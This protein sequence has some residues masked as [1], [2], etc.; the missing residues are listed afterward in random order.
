MLRVWSLCGFS[1]LSLHRLVEPRAF[2]ARSCMGSSRSTEEAAGETTM[3]KSFIRRGSRVA[4]TKSFMR[5]GI[6]FGIG[7]VSVGMTSFMTE[8]MM[9]KDPSTGNQLPTTLRVTGDELDLIALGS[10]AVT[11]LKIN[12]YVLGMYVDKSLLKGSTDLAELWKR[13]KG[14]N[15]QICFTVN[16]VRN[17]NAPHLVRGF[18]TA[19]DK[20]KAIGKREDAADFLDDLTSEQVGEMDDAIERFKSAFPQGNLVPG[21]SLQLILDPHAETVEMVMGEQHAMVHSAW[22]AKAIYWSYVNPQQP[23]SPLFQSD[24]VENLNRLN[25]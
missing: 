4:R 9:R 3:F 6:A 19:L 1:W 13:L 2:R 15:A 23:S 24:L 10:K 22:L 18:L 21:E 20:I 25:N 12:V 8:S 16:P 7:A 11:F 14:S 17:T 5:N